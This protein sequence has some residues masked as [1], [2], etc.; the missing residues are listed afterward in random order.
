MFGHRKAVLEMPAGSA[1]G[2]GSMEYA[3]FWAR[4]VASLLDS[5]IVS[6]IGLVL[7][8]GALFAGLGLLANLLGFLVFVLY[9]PLLESSARQATFG[10]QLLGLQVTD[11]DGARVS[12]VRALMR[13]LGKILSAI[14]LYIGFI[15]AAFTGRKQALHD[16]LAK[17][18]VV[19]TGPSRLLKAIIIIVVLVIAVIA[20]MVAV[21]VPMFQKMMSGGMEAATKGMSREMEKAMRDAQKSAPAVKVAPPVAKPSEPA[22]SAPPA[23]VAVPA[24][25]ADQSSVKPAGK[26]AEKTAEKPA[27]VALAPAKPAADKPAAVEA[28]PAPAK[29]AAAPAAK[30]EPA[31]A[32]VAAP[33]VADKPR[34][35]RRAAPRKP[36]APAAVAEAA[37]MQPVQ[38]PR[39]NDVMTAVMSRDHAG[40]AEALRAGFWP[41]R[42]D[43]N[44]VTPLMAAALNGDFAMTELLLRNG[45]DPNRSAPGGSVMAFATKGGNAKVVDMLRRAGAR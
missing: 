25:A 14:P 39:Y 42:P 33:A 28:K 12:F 29:P 34:T 16:I 4:F 27:A 7:A 19:R 22:P 38:T 26:P 10:K 41:D 8:V 31:P 24:P 5:M 45:A 30:A 2:G 21:A 15:L 9:F 43:S 32:P 35:V 37:P 18:L 17:C 44:G 40:A 3:G 36:A 6:I 23:S 1:A 13:N 20:I 11:L